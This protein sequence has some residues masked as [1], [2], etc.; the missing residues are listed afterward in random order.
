ML[1]DARRSYAYV[2]YAQ[3]S[4]FITCQLLTLSVMK[5]IKQFDTDNETEPEGV[6]TAKSLWW[7]KRYKVAESLLREFSYK[8]MDFMPTL[9]FDEYGQKMV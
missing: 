8:T 6:H 2:P 7:Q 4:V 5:R 9:K 1:V 3:G